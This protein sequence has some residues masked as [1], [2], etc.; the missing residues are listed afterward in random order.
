MTCS[1]ELEILW[2]EGVVLS[3]DSHPAKMISPIKGN[4]TTCELSLC[5]E[6]VCLFLGD[7]R[8]C[9]EFC[10]VLAVIKLRHNWSQ[11]EISETIL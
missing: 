8:G 7:E 5:E 2:G 1:G 9:V 3:H 10:I 11:G 4:I 6:D